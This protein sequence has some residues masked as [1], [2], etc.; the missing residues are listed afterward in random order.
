[1]I[2]VG[3]NEQIYIFYSVQYI[4]IMIQATITGTTIF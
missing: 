1:M 4:S 3:H 2:Y